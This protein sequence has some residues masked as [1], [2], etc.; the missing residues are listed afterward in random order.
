M[1]EFEKI[2]E[3][4]RFHMKDL[5]EFLAGMYVVVVY[6]RIFTVVFTAVSTHIKARV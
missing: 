3:T 6:G 1:Q 2:L 4:N 5:Y